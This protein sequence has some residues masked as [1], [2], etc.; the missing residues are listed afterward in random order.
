MLSVGATSASVSA[1]RHAASSLSS[2]RPLRPCPDE[3]PDLVQRDEV[4]HL[5]AHGRHADLEPA[6]GA[7][8][9]VAHADHDGRPAAGDAPDPVPRAQVVD[10][11]VEGSRMHRERA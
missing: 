4:A 3:M 7:A 10:V 5:A 2:R 8:V 6:L 9:A 1:K 11:E